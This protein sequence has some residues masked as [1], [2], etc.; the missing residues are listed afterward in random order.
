MESPSKYKV[1]GLMSGTSLDGLDLIYCEF[2][3]NKKGWTFAL[4]AS[5]TKR[6]TPIWKEKLAKAHLASGEDILLLDKEY[7]FLL[8]STCN[9]FI[10][11]NKIKSI[12]FIASHGHTVFHQPEKKFTFQLG[13][14]SA[15]HSSSSLPVINDFRSVDVL[16][17]GRGA[18]LVPIGDHFL[19]SQYDVCLNLG[20]IANLSLTEKGKR[21]AYDICFVNQGLNHLAYK[22]KKSYDKN[23]KGA[24]R[25][26]INRVMLAD[27]NKRYAKWRKSRPS[28]GREDFEKH[29]IPILDNEKISINDRLRTFCESICDEIVF[30]IRHKRKKIKLFTTGGGALNVFL[31]NLLQKK[32]SDSTLVVVPD[33]E[34]VNYKEAI[35]FA[36]LGVLRVRNEINILKSVTG[37]HSNSSAGV[38]IGF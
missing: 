7:G 25:G 13:D 2:N 14:G 9:S 4:K 3:K 17:G 38:M 34:I 27:L 29:F 10:K 16:K 23:G 24:S 1:V 26:K 35:I 31:I 8:G 33:S 21:I 30:C 36:F 5:E 15:I 11:K 6:Y 22:M 28:L 18:P 20:G 19:F 12:D 32:L 37:A